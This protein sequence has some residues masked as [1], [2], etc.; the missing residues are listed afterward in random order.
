MTRKTLGALLILLFVVSLG[1]PTGAAQDTY[2]FVMVNPGNEAAT[3]ERARDFLDRMGR[4]LH[5][6]VAPLQDRPVRGWVTNERDSVPRYL[7]RDPD[8]A[9]VPPSVYLEHLHGQE[10]ATPV[11]EIPRFDA[12]A[13]R[14]H[15]VVPTNGPSSI[16]DLRG[17]VIR[18]QGFS[19]EYLARVVFP[20]S[21][22]PGR[23]VT[24]EPAENMNDEVFLMTEGPMGEETPADALLLDAD[25]KHF[26][27]TDDLV[28]SQLKVIWTSRPLP[29]DLV[30]ALGASWDADARQ[31]LQ[32]ALF[33]MGEHELGADLLDLMNSAGLIPVKKTRLSEVT[34]QYTA[35]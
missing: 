35:Q 31:S 24:V 8:L 9:F 23:D 25:L 22:Q 32:S 11:A 12:P 30:V 2:H 15:L 1:A 7:D 21:F 6:T 17:G 33:G 18:G 10:H 4:Y 3:G 20:S 34:R 19:K 13:Q 28:W 5:E 27:E 26:F 14:Y 16:E 29:R